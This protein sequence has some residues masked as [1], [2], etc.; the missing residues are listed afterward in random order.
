MQVC[1]CLVA[2][3][4]LEGSDACG[5]K[6]PIGEDRD[7]I[8]GKND[9]FEMWNMT[10]ALC[11]VSNLYGERADNMNG[12]TMNVSTRK[13]SLKDFWECARGCPFSPLKISPRCPIIMLAHQPEA[14]L[15]RE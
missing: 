7:Y 8:E 11:E 9:F 4:R 14:D 3:Q 5:P 15:Y 13:A 1:Q 12:Q 6:R 2:I 10:W